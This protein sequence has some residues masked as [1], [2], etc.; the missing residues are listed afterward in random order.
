MDKCKKHG[1]F[2]GGVFES[3]PYCELF[4]LRDCNA[5]LQAKRNRGRGMTKTVFIGVMTLLSVLALRSLRATRHIQQHLR[6]G[7]YVTCGICGK[8][9]EEILE[10][11]SK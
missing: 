7:E 10:E 2:I 3:C 4:A 6:P 9:A 5:N 1:E 8:S 11:T